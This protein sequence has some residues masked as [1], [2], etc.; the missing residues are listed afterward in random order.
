MMLKQTKKKTVRGE[1]RQ[2]RSPS[3]VDGRGGKRIKR[4][5][6]GDKRE[7]AQ[8][9]SC[10]RFSLQKRG[11]KEHVLQERDEEKIA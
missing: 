6:R 3:V 4:S 11:R 10:G 8:P 9:L 2:V 5:P 7:A 1:S